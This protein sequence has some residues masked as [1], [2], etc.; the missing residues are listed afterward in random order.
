M[1][2]QNYGSFLKRIWE[3]N[4]IDKIVNGSGKQYLD[5]LLLERNKIVSY[6]IDK[7]LVL[8]LLQIPSESKNVY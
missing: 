8:H 1:K 5:N 4:A 7:M 2:A 3:E 6:T